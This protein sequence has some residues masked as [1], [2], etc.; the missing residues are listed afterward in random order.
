MNEL[1]K[2]GQSMTFRKTMTVAEQGFYTG[3]TGNLGR[4]HVDRAYAR[5]HGHADMLVFELAAAGLFTTALGRVA[6][7][8]YRLGNVNIDF[9][10]P[11]SVGATV[12]ASV[13][14]IE[15]HATRLVFDLSATVDDVVVITG[16]AELVAMAISDV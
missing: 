10:A 2:I 14:V 15:E 9:R 16:R 4:S 7:P 11:I 13:T 5:D 6:G 12:A 3:I 8:G 1:S